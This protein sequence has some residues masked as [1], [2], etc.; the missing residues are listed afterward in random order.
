VPATSASPDPPRSQR[1]QARHRG[2]VLDAL[3][4]R[5]ELQAA[6]HP[7]NR[8]DDRRSVRIGGEPAQ[9]RLPSP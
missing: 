5:C 6:R 4:D 2:S 3:G 7:D 1:A 9:E 8:A